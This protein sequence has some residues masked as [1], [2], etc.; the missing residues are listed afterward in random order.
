MLNET[1]NQTSRGSKIFFHD[2]FNEG[3]NVEQIL[4]RIKGNLKI[5]CKESLQIWS[6]F[7]YCMS[8]NFV[9]R[10]KHELDKSS[11]SLLRCR[12]WASSEFSSFF[13]KVIIS[14]EYTFEDI[15]VYSS[16]PLL[17]FSGH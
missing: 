3:F 15:G 17:I 4:I 13:V 8:K 2:E 6:V 12:R 9:N 5:V 7:A 10:L 1:L 11:L 16:K 14:P